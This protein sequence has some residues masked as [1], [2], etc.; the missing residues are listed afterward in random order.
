MTRLTEDEIWVQACNGPN[1]GRIFGLGE[2]GVGLLRNGLENYLMNANSTNAYHT[3][4]DVEPLK[5]EMK[6]MKEK[7]DLSTAEVKDRKEK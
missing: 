4:E 2:Q 3:Y 5:T 6:T 1:N 7:L